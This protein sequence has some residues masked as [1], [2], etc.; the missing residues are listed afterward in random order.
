VDVAIEAC[1][2]AGVPLVVAGTGPELPRLQRLGGGSV[3]FTGWRTDEEVR[4]LYQDA[5]AVI[6]PG[7]E[8]FGMV[9]VEAQACGAP[10][11]ALNEG[12]AAESVV[13][14]TTGVL[15]G[16]RS[17]AS[18]AAGLRRALDTTFDPRALRANAMRFSR[19][20]FLAEFQAAVDDAIA[21]KPRAVAS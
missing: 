7:V 10:V 13:D 8:D 17:A 11:V 4:A 14:G 9:P 12:G 21:E 1:R 16:D 3:E 2:S 5:T 6:L 19:Q 20:R 15:V 18:L